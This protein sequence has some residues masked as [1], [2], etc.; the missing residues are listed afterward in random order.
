M[1]ACPQVSLGCLDGLDVS[2]GSCW[3][4]LPGCSP[5]PC[6]PWCQV[7]AHSGAVAG[8]RLRAKAQVEELGFDFW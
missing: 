5:I 3:A 7:W 2:M 4:P 1:S 6:L 8:G